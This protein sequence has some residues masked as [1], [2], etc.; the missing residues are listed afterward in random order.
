VPRLSPSSGRQRSSRSVSGPDCQPAPRFRYSSTPPTGARQ[1]H[2][3]LDGAVDRSYEAAAEVTAF[4][5]KYDAVLAGKAAFTPQKQR[6][7]DLF[8]GKAQCNARHRDGGPGED[9]LLP[10]SLRAIS[11]RSPIRVCRTMPSS[12]PTLAALPPTWQVHPT[13]IRALP[14][15]WQSTTC[16]VIPWW[17]INAGVRW[18]PNTGRFQVPTL[19]NVDKRL[20]ARFVKAYGHNGY[21]LTL[22][23]MVYFYNTR[24]LLPRCSADDPGEGATCWPAPETAANMNKSH[25]GKLGLSNDDEDAVV[26]FLGTLS[27]G[28]SRRTRRKPS[29]RFG[30]K[31]SRW[32]GPNRPKR[33][34]KPALSCEA[35][36][37]CRERR[38]AR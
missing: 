24:D 17:S 13:S 23:A 9:P 27:D 30:G 8:R 18:R 4:T 6:G 5:L 1:R 7:Y 22:K 37:P 21:F 14:A 16:S 2:L 10:T 36:P 15:S 25:V 19:R 31:A 38:C 32:P 20:D 3:R 33:P 12:S 29:G 28:F 26:A 11:A 35:L 34:R